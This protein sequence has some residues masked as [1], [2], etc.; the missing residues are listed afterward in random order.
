MFDQQKRLI[1]TSQH[2]HAH[3]KIA[4][5]SLISICITS[6]IASSRI[7]KKRAKA[8][9]N[10]ERW[11]EAAPASTRPRSGQDGTQHAELHDAP[12]GH[13]AVTAPL[14]GP[15]RGSHRRLQ[16]SPPGPGPRSPE[17]QQPTRPRPSRP[18]RSGPLPARPPATRGDHVR[19]RGLSGK[20][21]PAGPRPR[22]RP[23]TAHPRTAE[24]REPPSLTRFGG[25]RAVQASSCRRREARCSSRPEAAHGARRLR[26]RLPLGGSQ[27]RTAPRLRAAPPSA[28]PGGQVREAAA[29]SARIFSSA[30]SARRARRSVTSAHSGAAAARG[31]GQIA[32]EA[33]QSGAASFRRS[34]PCCTARGRVLPAHVAG[35][36]HKT[37]E[38]RS[39]LERRDG[40][41]RARTDGAAL[42]AEST[43]VV[44]KRKGCTS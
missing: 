29:G 27:V 42:L 30:A 38:L 7:L 9:R 16:R 22:A 18:A 25:R 10:T 13:P 20:G 17:R 39:E 44:R 35:R 11:E 28:S 8:T 23:Q 15:G 33:R 21:S 2:K 24:P 12:P 40:P 26:R 14:W 5:A 41:L 6:F 34:R 3:T 36:R 31:N 19:F 43:R 37:L 4:S 32:V 1:K